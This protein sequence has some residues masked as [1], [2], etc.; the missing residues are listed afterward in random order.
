MNIAAVVNMGNNVAVQPKSQQQTQVQNNQVFGNVFGQILSNQQ[1][2]QPVTP[3]LDESGQNLI[4]ELLSILNAESLEDVESLLGSKDLS[5]NPKE[6]KD[7]L[8]K[9]LGETTDPNE[10]LVES[11]VWD[12]LAGINEQA[13]QLTDAIMLSLN[14]KGPATPMEAKQAVELLK[15][16]QL[17]GKKSDLTLKQESTLFDLDQL[18]GNVKEAVSGETL[19]TNGSTNASN[20]LIVDQ[21]MKSNVG[22]VVIKQVVSQAEKVIETK[23][24]TS[25]VQGT[26]TTIIQTKVETVSI[27]LPAE[28]PGQSEEYLKELQKVMNRVQFGQ[29][30]GAN[31]LV[32]KLYPEHLGT[33]RIELIQKDGMLTAKMLAS[34]ALGKELLDSN[35]NHLRQ[36]LVSQ[37]I[38]V[39][40]LEITQ[41]LQDTTRQERNQTFHE[42][43]KQQQQQQEQTENSNDQQE[44]PFSFQ[45]YLEEMEV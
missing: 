5:I 19:L 22:Q 36:S 8:N 31:R 26:S 28:K 14:G 16:V 10:K 38:Q 40:K 12:I 39:D 24:V 29:A 23:E 20:Q 32:I 44:E 30:G 18:L 41:A 11:D 45:D 27:T 35:S 1:V 42:S 7:L 34:T 15:V 43:F 9:L 37:N 2:Q 33:I 4:Q 13:V 17:I 3:V 21:V 6:L 25:N